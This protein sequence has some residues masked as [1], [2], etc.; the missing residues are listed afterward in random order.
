MDD[1]IMGINC[2]IK[3]GSMGGAKAQWEGIG[4]C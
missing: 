4:G 2:P 3:A 1:G